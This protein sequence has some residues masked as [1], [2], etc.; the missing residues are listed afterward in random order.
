MLAS[1]LIRT[2]KF[3]DV[4]FGG[5]GYIPSIG[6]QSRRGRIHTTSRFQTHAEYAFTNTA[7]DLF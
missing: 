3:S 2:K 5:C 4:L 1:H 7:H 6:K